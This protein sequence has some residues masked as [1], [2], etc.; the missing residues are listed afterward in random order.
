MKTLQT[1]PL[2]LAFIIGFAL[3]GCTAPLDPDKP[4]SEFPQSSP[5]D[6]RSRGGAILSLCKW[7]PDTSPAAKAALAAMHDKE[8]IERCVIVEQCSIDDGQ[9][10]GFRRRD[11]AI[12]AIAGRRAIQL[13]PGHYTWQLLSQDQRGR[14]PSLI[15]F[16]SSSETI[17]GVRYDV[18]VLKDDFDQW[19]KDHNAP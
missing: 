1:A 10:A 18:E 8:T 12:F 4:V 6:F 16:P 17:D 11:A 2:A 3:C 9:I 15:T 5:H 13:P 14:Q 7:E 19:K